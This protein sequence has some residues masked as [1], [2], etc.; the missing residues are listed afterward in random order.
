MPDSERPASPESIVEEGP[1][2]IINVPLG[3][4]LA[5]IPTI[6]QRLITSY[7]TPSPKERFDHEFLQ[8][9][10]LYLTSNQSQRDHSFTLTELR[11]KNECYRLG[12]QAFGRVAIELSM[13]RNQARR[14]F[15]HELGL[16]NQALTEVYVY[17]EQNGDPVL[18]GID[19]LLMSK[20]TSALSTRRHAA[21]DDFYR[22][23]EVLP[24][25]PVWAERGN[26]NE[27]LELNE[28]EIASTMFRDEVERFLRYL[29]NY[30]TYPAAEDHEKYEFQPTEES[31]PLL[32]LKGKDIAD[33]RNEPEGITIKATG[34]NVLPAQFRD[35]TAPPHMTQPGV[36]HV[37]AMT[38]QPWYTSQNESISTYANP[39]NTTGQHMG[40][41]VSVLLGK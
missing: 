17:D 13:S 31:S 29:T 12:K 23:C 5:T 32:E 34:P 37:A 10:F 1:S 26:F 3:L 7:R 33:R 41:S 14:F 2:T 8:K 28:F 6:D 36:G 11:R 27:F 9:K 20:L 39:I 35:R 30:H 15:K 24:E 19:R 21:S 38:R 22:R 4:P 18:Y 16:L 25:Y 40:G